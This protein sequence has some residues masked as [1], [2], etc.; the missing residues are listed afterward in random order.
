M[1]ANFKTRFWKIS[2]WYI[3]FFILLLSFR[4]IYGYIET[5]NN[6]RS[7]YSDNFF[8]SIDNLR[9]NY[10]SEKIAMKGDIQISS[11]IAS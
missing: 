1:K 9:K 3:A 2:K 4:L 11:N 5:D 8:N 7:D 6:T 10:A